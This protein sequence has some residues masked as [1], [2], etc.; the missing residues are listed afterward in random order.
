MI[1]LDALAAAEKENWVWHGADC[2]KPEYKRC[3][4]PL[5]R[6][7]ADADV[8]REFDLAVEDVRE[9]RLLLPE[10]KSSAGWLDRDTLYVGTD[11]G[12]G[13]MTTSGYPRIAKEWKRGTPL[14]AAETVSRASPS[15]MSVA[16]LP[17][18]HEGLRAR[19]RLRGVTFYTNEMFLRRGR[20]ARQDR[21]ARQR[22]RRTSTATCSSS[23]CATT[24]RWAGRPTPPAR[25]SPPTSRTSSGA[26]GASTSSSSRPSASRSPASARRSHHVLLNEL[27]NVRNRVYVLDAARTARGRASRCP[28]MP[29]F[30]TV[31][32]AAVDDEE[33]D[34]YFMTVTDYLTPTSLSLGTVGQGRAREAQAAARVLRRAGPRGQPARG[35]L[36]GRHARPVLPGRRAR[37]SRSTAR[38]RRSSTATAASRSRWC[39]ATAAGVGA[40]WLE[41]GG[42]YV[43]ANIRGG[44]EFGPKW[45]QAALKAEP[46][47]ARTRTSSPSPRT[48]SRRKVT[49][50]AAPRHP[51][52]QQRRPARGQHAHACAPTSSAPSSARCRCSTC[53]ATTRCWPARPGWA[54]TATPT[55]RRSGRSSG[56]SRRTRTSSRA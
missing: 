27:D 47:H 7:G 32:A 2:L 3:L 10:A 14:A 29:E 44:G 52:R 30:G 22:E 53:G 54:S 15:D 28:G 55:T 36:E 40:A 31:S 33:S 13:S 19:L 9:G 11:F 26:S 51:G 24:G 48:S 17:R 35:D 23:S 41:Q 4:V 38:T 8:V 49:S 25:S 5:S 1:D 43:V 46:A 39:P 18:P 50:P 21:Q 56:R 6:G 45:H 42:V 37:S 34:D 16:A 20:Q 12:P